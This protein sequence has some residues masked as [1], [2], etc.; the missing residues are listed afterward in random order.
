ML[1]FYSLCR[2]TSRPGL[3][4]NR[5]A[6]RNT[7]LGVSVAPELATEDNKQWAAG[8]VL[9]GYFVLRKS[10]LTAGTDPTRPVVSLL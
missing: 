10:I 1:S 4:C 2:L 9:T 8:Y 6:G 5:N 7:G 3:V